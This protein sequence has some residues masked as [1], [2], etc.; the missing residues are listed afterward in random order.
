[1]SVLMQ[2]NNQWSYR[3][4]DE[5]FL[6]LEDMRAHFHARRAGSRS[7]V[8]ANHD[9][10]ATADQ[11]SDGISIAFRDGRPD[12]APTNWSFGQIATL[13]GAP[14]SYLRKL[15]A[16]LV[17]DCINS[18]LSRR[19]VDEC[20]FFTTDG[21][22]TLRAATGPNYG[23]VWNSDV[24]DSVIERFG[25]GVTGD[26][27]VPG[28]FGQAV[29][30]TR[31]NT[32]LYGSDR[33]MWIFLAD[34]KNRIEMPGRR[35]GK[36]GS[37]ARGFF[38]WNSEEGAATLGVGT[39]LFDYVCANRIV[40]GAAQYKEIKIRHSSGAPHRFVEEIAPRLAAYADSTTAATLDTLAAARGAIVTDVAEFLA[41]R[42][43]NPR[44]VAAITA[45]HEADEGRPMETMWDI[46]TGTT[47]YARSIPHQA[48]RVGIERR[49]GE[50]LNLVAA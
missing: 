34:E 31:G 8:A 47:A 6:S 3:L 41:T 44:Q 16:P 43:F 4:A 26:W 38:L 32:T 7:F 28:E 36:T 50:L 20:G 39:F 33:D 24:V 2:A 42:Q 18:G 27:R 1:M 35:N 10:R 23:R 15:P 37:L 30:V 25:D 40:W 19:N 17:A 48:D 5:R 29:Q 21:G 22:A 14:A 11:N 46:V 9:V 45:A 49:A 12:V 13:S